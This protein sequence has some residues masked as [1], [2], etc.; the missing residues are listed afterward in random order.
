MTALTTSMRKLYRRLNYKEPGICKDIKSWYENQS[1]QECV[2]LSSRHEYR[3]NLPRT[4][5][6]EIAPFFLQDQTALLQERFVARIPFAQIY[7][8]LGFVVLPDQQFA[9][10]YLTHHEPFIYEHPIYFQRWKP[11][12]K[13][14]QLRGSYF[15][16]LGVFCHTYYHWMHDV[17]LQ[18]YKIIDYLPSDVK[19]LL[20]SNLSDLQRKTLDLIGLSDN[21]LTYLG[22]NICAT[23]EELYFIP[24]A[25]ITRF[26]SPQA[27]NW[28]H[29]L[30]CNYFNLNVTQPKRIYIS[31]AYAKSRRV[32]N[33]VEVLNILMTYGFEILHLEFLS[34]EEQA[35]AFYNAEF[36]ISPHGAGLVNM[37]F[38]RANIKVLELFFEPIDRRTH[39]WSLAEAREIEYYYITGNSIENS[40][41]E[42]D[43]YIPI[44]KLKAILALW[45]L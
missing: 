45:N 21:R 15:S 42:P 12:I 2:I 18:F 1:N 33:E 22:S 26:D 31:R 9:Y 40:D 19:I 30:A 4:I 34:L 10:D 16:V 20:P 27:V 39:F 43:I 11:G 14:V 36:I 5:E 8:P 29:N 28:F 38:S 24:P 13:K 23:I 6:N 3:R 44:H 25:T 35:L 32:I 37:L 7:S 17:L 41:E